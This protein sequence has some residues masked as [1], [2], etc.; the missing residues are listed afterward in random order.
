MA[1]PSVLTVPSMYG[2]GILYSG[3]TV[4]GPEQGDNGTIVNV[5]GGVITKISD[6]YYNATSDGTSGSSIRPK[7]DFALTNG[8]KYK[9]E[10]IPKNQSGT[11]DCRFYDG[12]SYVFLNNNLKNPINVYFTAN[13]SE[14]LAF[15]GSVSFNVDFNISLKEI[16]QGSDFDFTR[17]TTGTRINEEGYIEDVPYNLFSHSE[18]FSYGAYAKYQAGISETTTQSPISGYY[19]QSIYN[20]NTGTTYSFINQN[21]VTPDRQDP[22]T[23]SLYAKKSTFNRIGISNRS[24]DSF[25]VIYDLDNGTVINTYSGSGQILASSIR[26]AGNGFYLC[27]VTLDKSNQYNIHPIPNNISDAQ[28]LLGTL[29][30][31][32]IGSVNIFG[33]QVVKGDKPKNYLPTTDRVNLPRLNYPVY[34]GCPS[35]LMEEQRTNLVQNSNNADLSLSGNQGNNIQINSSN[36]FSPEGVNNA[37]EIEV[38]G[39]SQPRVESVAIVDATVYVVSAYVKK[40]TGDFFGLGFYQQDIGNQFAKFDLNTG[41]F[42]AVSSNGAV[43]Q[44]ATNIYNSKITAYKNNWYRISCN[45]LTGSAAAHSQFKFL[46]MSEGTA[47]TTFSNGVVGEKFLLYGRQV[48]KITSAARVNSNPTSL[49]PTGGAAVTRNED[50]ALY[51]GL[52]TTDTFNDSEGV[53]FIET[54]ALVN[55]VNARGISIN[56]GSGNNRVL[57]SYPSSG[58]SSITGYVQST[59]GSGASMTVTGIDTTQKHKVAIKYKVNDASLFIDGVKRDVDINLAMP[60]GLKQLDFS[61][62]IGIGT[63]EYEGNLNAIAV[64]KTALTDTELANLTSYNNHDLFIPYRSRMQMISADQELQCTEH[65]I[66]RFLWN[67]DY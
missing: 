18:D 29:S 30:Y 34:G 14:F 64:Y 44:S 33:A 59:A 23:F 56:A 1:T 54:E 51:A 6:L 35:L 63:A 48:E 58:D 12:A 36:N 53:L 60:V 19:V 49:I 20:T 17:G 9:L 38:T 15:N 46:A 62:G 50:K 52:G 66:T 32:E 13:G 39:A 7:I 27:S 41:T 65:D 40:V 22:T 5:A 61:N 3:P 42:I 21:L 55:E 45:I 25:G 24:N 4:F 2:D 47:S 26:S 57:I 37:Q 8:K 10:I 28:L 43:S 16:T 31:T 67:Q 11:I